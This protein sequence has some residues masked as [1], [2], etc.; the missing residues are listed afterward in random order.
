MGIVNYIKSVYIIWCG[1]IHITIK[2]SANNERCIGAFAND[3]GMHG[4]HL[5]IE[6]EVQIG[7]E[8]FVHVCCSLSVSKVDFEVHSR[9]HKNVSHFQ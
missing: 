7:Y 1:A 5:E 2:E 6:Y 4:M 8:P 3:N 9:C